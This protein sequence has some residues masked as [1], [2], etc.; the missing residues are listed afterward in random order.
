VSAQKET[1]IL[2]ISEAQDQLIGIIESLKDFE[3]PE[4]ELVYFQSNNIDV[5]DIVKDIP[6]GTADEDYIY[7]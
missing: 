3:F 2:A 7:I 6:T 5:G 1:L 4:G